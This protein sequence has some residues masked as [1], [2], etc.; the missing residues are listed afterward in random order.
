MLF[1]TRNPNE[2]PRRNSL[3]TGFIPVDVRALDPNDPNIVRVRVHAV[4]QAGLELGKCP[5]WPFFRS[6]EHT[7]E[8][9]SHSELVC[10]LLLEKKKAH[11]DLPADGLGPHRRW[12]LGRESAARPLAC[13]PALHCRGA[14]GMAVAVVVSS[15][16]RC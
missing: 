15:R 3:L 10:R 16:T 4:V 1:S 2:I 7:S 8:L 11:H 6:E 13:S 5:I 9:Q 14:A 12:R